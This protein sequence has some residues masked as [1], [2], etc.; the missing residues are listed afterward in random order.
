M[1]GRRNRHSDEGGV[2]YRMRE[3]V[4][5]VGDDYWIEDPGR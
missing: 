2:Q 1:R 4:F 3:K 5:S